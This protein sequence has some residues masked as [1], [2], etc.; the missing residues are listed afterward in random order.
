[1]RFVN[2]PTTSQV[3]SGGAP[4]GSLAIQ[5]PEIQFSE[6][7]SW[8]DVKSIPHGERR[9]LYI[10]ARFDKKPTGV[11]NPNAKEILYIG[12]THGKSQSIHKRLTMFFKAARVGDMIHKH[13]GGNRFNRELAGDLNNIYA[14][15]FAPIVE[16][17]CYLNA[18]IF[19]AERKLIWDYIVK[20]GTIPACNGY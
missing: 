20:W 9:G 17:D 12:E 5:T 18:F 2:S 11:A 13:S 10:I 4:R 19:Y 7:Y 3:I 1:L 8:D 14:A 6:W 15:G 16:D